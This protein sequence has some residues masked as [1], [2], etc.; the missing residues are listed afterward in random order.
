MRFDM[1]FD[2]TEWDLKELESYAVDLA[3]DLSDRATKKSYAKVIKEIK[4]RKQQEK[5]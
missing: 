4:T 2:Y 3:A 5:C 1:D